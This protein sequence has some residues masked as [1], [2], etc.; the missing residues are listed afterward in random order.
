M[1]AQTNLSVTC[2]QASKGSPNSGKSKGNLSTSSLSNSISSGHS[3]SSPGKSIGGPGSKF[4]AKDKESK[5]G[6]TNFSG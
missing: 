3:G 2:S 6:F 1:F 5:K 4:N